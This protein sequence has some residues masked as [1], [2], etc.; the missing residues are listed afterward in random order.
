MFEQTDASAIPI[1]LRGATSTAPMC[2]SGIGVVDRNGD[3]FPGILTCSPTLCISGPLLGSSR[4]H[5]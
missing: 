4:P 2:E 3:A 1:E 5:I